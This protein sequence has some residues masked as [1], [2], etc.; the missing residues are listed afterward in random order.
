MIIKRK[1]KEQGDRTKILGD[2]KAK[3]KRREGGKKHTLGF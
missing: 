1:K 2:L 3:R